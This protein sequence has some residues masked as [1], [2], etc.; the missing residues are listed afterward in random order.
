MSIPAYFILGTPTSGRRGIV[1]NSIDA[2]SLDGD[3]SIV[4]VSENESPSDF[5]ATIAKADNAG[6]VKYSD[7]FDAAEKLA[8]LDPEK[9]TRVFFIAD[10]TKNPADEVESFKS[11]VDGGAIRL[12]RIWSV[13]DCSMYEKFPKQTAKYLDMLA[14]FADC[15]VLSRRSGASNRSVEDLRAHW[16]KM[17]H[18]HLVEYA[19]KKFATK[20]PMEMLVEEARRISMLFD[21]FDP[22]DELELDDENLPEEPFSLERKPDPYLV[23]LQN[24]MRANPIENPAQYALKAREMEN[25][26]I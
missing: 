13:V 23:K 19:D 7:A 25:E 24:S 11:L 14:H 21:E 5:D 22:V 9:I 8:A 20:S 16:E 3:F 15:V 4:F 26:K 1:W 6:I 12:A 18:P 2:G 17:R 10:S